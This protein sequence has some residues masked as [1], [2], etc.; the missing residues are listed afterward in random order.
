MPD[1]PNRVKPGDIIT[2]DFINSMLDVLA[3][4]DQR[5]SQLE[6]GGGTPNDPPAIGSI[7][8]IHQSSSRG[9][10]LVPGDELPYPQRFKLSNHTNRPL[11]IALSAEVN[12]ASGNWKKSIAIKD[13]SNRSISQMVVAPNGRAQDFI[14]DV[15]APEDAEVG[16]EVTLTVSCQVG[17]PHNKQDQATLDLTV[18]EKPGPPVTRSIQFAQAQAPPKL[19]NAAPGTVLRFSFDLRYSATEKPFDIDSAFLIMLTPESGADVSEW[20]GEFANFRT[21]HDAKAGTFGA[22]IPLSSTA[23]VSQRVDFDLAVPTRDA[24]SDKAVTLSARVTA[25]DLKPPI[26]SVYKE[27]FKIR[28]QRTA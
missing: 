25:A 27:T 14:V 12:A 26:T 10:N 21:D 15:S 24:R 1:I 4:L 9:V 19:D 8:V 11:A 6:S 2:S 22:K 20:V 18:A 3:D 17:P 28:V 16:D 23:G 5:V 7:A 13:T